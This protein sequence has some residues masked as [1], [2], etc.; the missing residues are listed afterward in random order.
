MSK[1]GELIAHCLMPVRRGINIPGLLLGVDDQIIVSLFSTYGKKLHA[2]RIRP[3]QRRALDL[4][5]HL[6]GAALKR[7][8]ESKAL[9]ASCATNMSFSPFHHSQSTG[10]QGDN[11]YALYLSLL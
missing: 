11:E 9:L 4:E 3:R 8:P 10:V 1:R 6:K 5:E 2:L 7:S